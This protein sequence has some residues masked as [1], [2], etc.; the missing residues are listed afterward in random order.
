MAEDI[1][2]I[3]NTAEQEGNESSFF[4]L[5]T[6]IRALVLNWQWFLLSIIISL[7]IAYLILRYTTPTYRANAQMFVKAPS[8]GGNVSIKGFTGEVIQSYGLENEKLILKSNVVSTNVVRDLKLYT[9]Y[10]MIGR[11]RERPLYMNQPITVD[12][13]ASHL[14]RLNAPINLE[15]TRDGDK[16]HVTG[17]YYVPLDEVSFNGPFGINQTLKKFPTTIRT[18][19]GYLSFSSNGRPLGDGETMAVTINSPARV[20]GKFAGNL[21]IGQ[22]ENASILNLTMTDVLP[23]RAMDYLRQLV[24]CYN[25]QANDDKN[26]TAIRTED[27]INDRIAKIS[28]ELNTAESSLESFKRQQNLVE[29]RTNAREANANLTAAENKLRQL[30]VQMALLNDVA[31]FVMQPSNK[32]QLMPANVSEGSI[33]GLIQQHNALVHKRNTLLRSA[34][35]T[36]P[37]VE[38]ITQQLE[39]LETSIALTLNQARHNLEFQRSIA[40]QQLGQYQSEVTRSPLQERVLTQIGRQQEVKSGLYL[41]SIHSR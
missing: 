1:K 18:K 6:V 21:G 33:A 36:S 30:D 5:Q 3:Q 37:A 27:F 28:G 38:P 24:V 35:E 15:I 34:A 20:S 9:E 22:F 39:E 16:Y 17:T 4:D 2:N 25:R 13:D 26:E 8:T 14:E 11:V 7:G 32:F 40:Q 19:A 10:R 12:I 23:Q 29:L 31:N 41:F